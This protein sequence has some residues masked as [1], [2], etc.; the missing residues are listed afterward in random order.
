MKI[1]ISGGEGLLA[2][3]IIRA[4]IISRTKHKFIILTHNQMNVR[5]HGEVLRAVSLHKPDVFLHCAAMT[6]PMDN[7]NYWQGM[8][9]NT[10]IIGS[11]VPAIVCHNSGGRTRLV[12]ISTDF[13]YPGTDG[14]Y[15]EQSPLQPINNYAKSKLAGEMA[16][17]MLPNSLILRCAFTECPFRHPK[18]FIDCFKSYLYA[19][20]A[21]VF[22]LELINSGYA[23]VVNVGGNRSTVYDFAKESRPDVGKITRAEVGTWIPRDI[24]MVTL[25]MQRILKNDP[26]L[27][28][29]ERRD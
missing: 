17:Q 20:M 11:A 9:I 3:H 10:N 4:S 24:S 16:A 18:A 5:N 8:S 28:Y 13:V 25:L 7:H 26:T 1:L 2:Q 23:G 29:P 27:Q 14:Y 22:I 12:Y 6:I 15:T 19:D 21:A